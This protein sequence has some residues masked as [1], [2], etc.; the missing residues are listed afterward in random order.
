M[1]TKLKRMLFVVGFVCFLAVVFFAITTEITEVEPSGLVGF[2]EIEEAPVLQEEPLWSRGSIGSS[3]DLEQEGNTKLLTTL[4]FGTVQR[5]IANALGVRS[6]VVKVTSEYPPFDEVAIPWRDSKQT[7]VYVTLPS[8]WVT[9]RTARIGSEV[10]VLDSLRALITSVVPGAKTSFH[11][12]Q[13]PPTI[14][15]SATTQE[16]YAKQIVLLVGLFGLL[17]ASFIVDHRK[18]PI[19]LLP[20]IHFE[21]PSEEAQRIVEMSYGEAV[22]AIDALHGEHKMNVLQSIVLL[23]TP[24]EAAPI[25]QVKT[26]AELTESI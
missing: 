15:R 16:S 22:H 11:I 14:S 6:A 7:V 26:E 19:D 17:F 12:V 10:A 13:V 4:N 9:Q 2:V 1:S 5:N 21:N 3:G 23:E 20:A 25:V 24:S 18:T 8:T